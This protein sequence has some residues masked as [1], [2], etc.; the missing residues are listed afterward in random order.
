[1]WPSSPEV[2]QRLWIY[3]LFTPWSRC[4]LLNALLEAATYSLRDNCRL[5]RRCPMKLRRPSVPQ[6]VMVATSLVVFTTGGHFAARAVIEGHQSRQLEE[7]TDVALRR[8][9]LA[10]DFG[11]ATLDELVKR[12]PL[13]C[14]PASLQAVRL[15]VYQR[16]AV[17]DIR[18]V[19]RDGSVICSAYSETLEFDNGWVDRPDML[20][21]D[22]QRLLLFHV[23]QFSGVALGVLRDVDESQSLV[24]ILGINSY[25]F[26]IMPA[27][28]R[29]HSEVSLELN[30]GSGLGRFSLKRHDEFSQLAS[31]GQA[32]VRY[33]LHATIRV[34][35]S[36]LQHWDNE[37][38][39]PTM[40]IALGLGLAFGLLLTRAT[41]RLEGPIADIDRALAR[42]EFKP[43]FQPIFDLRTGS[44]R[45]C[46]VLARWIREDGTII[47]P[48]NFIPLAESSGRIEAMTWLI[49]GAALKDM[50]PRLREDKLFK[51]SVNVTPR[52]LLSDGFVET[53]RRVV[54]AAK[55]SVRQIV[56]EVTERS[57]LPDLD[58]AAAVVKELR[59]LGFR[60]AIDDVGVGHSGLS[61]IKGLGVNTIKIDKFFVDTIT[62]DGSAATIVQMLVRLARDL[63]MTVIAEGIETSD[64]VQALIACGVEEGQGYFVSPPL[65]FAK[66]DQLLEI[67]SA[68]AFAEAAVKQAALVA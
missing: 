62:E 11:A 24:A 23:D 27:E 15:Q 20:R 25:V 45:G 2:V 40:L 68:R 6:I 52:H 5:T 12:G 31:F 21:S 39:W 9:E 14:D 16:S 26:D 41:A 48:M 30:N 35:R 64:Q 1:M 34:E 33:P 53:L 32:S 19:N 43:F 4:R 49:L 61:Q 44:I 10:V 22:D 17:K 36:A 38:Y 28:L 59:E 47:P 50:Y 60:V 65:P 58:R 66:F 18:L 57:E 3:G 51:L 46:E 54:V 8:S 42:H 56:L 29:A 13:N 37:A 63:G 67:R 7:L 55:V